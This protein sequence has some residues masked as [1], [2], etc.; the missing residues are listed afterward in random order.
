MIL[1]YQICLHFV[2]QKYYN[3]MFKTGFSTTIKLLNLC[4]LVVKSKILFC[5]RRAGIKRMQY[6]FLT[7][8]LNIKHILLINT[9][10]ILQNNLAT[11][12]LKIKRGILRIWREHRNKSKL[13]QTLYKPYVNLLLIQINIHSTLK[14]IVNA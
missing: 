12:L 6:S 7:W 11:L 3:P 14:D 8:I 4:V 2:Y 5:G 10:I 1:L 13:P 9:R